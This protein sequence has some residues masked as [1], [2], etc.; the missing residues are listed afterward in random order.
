M[1]TPTK[2]HVNENGFSTFVLISSHRCRT[3]PVFHQ[4]SG[5]ALYFSE[6]EEEEEE[7]E[8]EKGLV[9]DLASHCIES[10]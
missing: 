6:E 2:L 5:C 8:E 10:G 7:K 3:A 1:S 4:F 9:G